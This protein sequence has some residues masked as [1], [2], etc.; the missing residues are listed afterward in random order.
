MEK[1]DFLFEN[2][3]VLLKENNLYKQ[4]KMHVFNFGDIRGTKFDNCMENCN[5]V[6]LIANDGLGCCKKFLLFRNLRLE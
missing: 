5:F 1:N 2:R 6:R 4:Q 3:V